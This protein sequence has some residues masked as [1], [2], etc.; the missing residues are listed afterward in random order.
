MNYNFETQIVLNQ[1]G[2][3]TPAVV[4]PFRNA[5]K[6]ISSSAFDVDPLLLNPAAYSRLAAGTI[7]FAFLS[8]SQLGT[9]PGRVLIGNAGGFPFGFEPQEFVSWW[10][11]GGG[12][13]L[14]SGTHVLPPALRSVATLTDPPYA[15]QPYVAFP[16]CLVLSDGGWFKEALTLK[17]MLQGKY[18]DGS[19]MSFRW[20]GESEQASDLAFPNIVTPSPVATVSPLPDI[21]NGVYNGVKFNSP[22]GDASPLAPSVGLFP[23]WPSVA[24]SV[25]DYGLKHFYYRPWF[26]GYVL[27]VVAVNKVFYD[28]LTA[29]QQYWI[30]TAA[31][32]CCAQSIADQINTQDRYVKTFQEMGAVIHESL[33]T[34]VLER[35]RAATADVHAANAAADTT[36]VYA[37]I[38]SHMRNHMKDNQVRWRDTHAD[39]KWRF[40]VTEIEADTP[41]AGF[42]TFTDGLTPPTASLPV[43]GETVTIDATMYTWKSV[44][45]AP[46][47]VKIGATVEESIDNL[48]KAINLT[49]TATVHYST[50]TTKHPTVGGAKWSTTVLK[51]AALVAGAAGNSIAIADG[52]ANGW[53]SDAGFLV[54]GRHETLQ[55]NA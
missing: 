30:T 21:I 51:A 16:T 12:E 11:S 42:L 49:G 55:P 28:G 32:A 54:G 34:D 2:N 7:K 50:G 52:M 46:F 6:E 13:A 19:Q 9:L 26:S 20:F 35:L 37:Q 15:L 39:R 48:V 47:Q 29:Q 38:L 5:L 23:N 53:W 3:T 24:G 31:R 27:R 33:P 1:G 45:S 25:I 44:F 18:S 4:D 40:Q 17:K 14:I 36:G 10:Y 8:G 22:E 41:A 43:D